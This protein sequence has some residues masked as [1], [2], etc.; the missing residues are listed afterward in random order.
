MLAGLRAGL[1]GHRV[2]LGP[3]ANSGTAGKTRTVPEMNRHA[4]VPALGAALAAWRDMLAQITTQDLP[5]ATPNPGWDVAHVINHSIA[6]T[7]KFTSFAVGA[8]DRPHTPTQHFLGAD[9]RVAFNDTADQ[10]IAAW[11]D[12]DLD[13]MC[14]L[15]FGTFPA[16]LAAG[17]NLF[18]LLAHSWD[19]QQATGAPFTCPPTAWAAGL[20]AAQRVIGE[21][22]DPR[23]Y[24]PELP[25]VPGAPAQLRLLRYLGR[26]QAGNSN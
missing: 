19:I 14:H 4:A 24:A 25:P 23:H 21:Q 5:L 22:R 20:D 9:H 7:S 12:A 2:P 26:A 13:R 15:R 8:T 16:E 11:R 1:G 3:H 10:A 6:V 18:D 17:I